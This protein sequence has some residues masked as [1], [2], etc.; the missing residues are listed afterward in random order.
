MTQTTASVT[1]SSKL[2][3]DLVGKTMPIYA[4]GQKANGKIGTLDDHLL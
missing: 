3:E 2:V 1:R 4:V